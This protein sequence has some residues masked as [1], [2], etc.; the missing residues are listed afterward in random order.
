MK[1][2]KNLKQIKW[3]I[4]IGFL[5]VGLT[6]G[7]LA[8]QNFYPIL[9]AQ[10]S[11][12]PVGRNL[13]TQYQREIFN[14]AQK[15]NQIFPWT[16]FELLDLSQSP[17]GA[18]GFWVNPIGQI[19]EERF[20]GL[21]ARVN[22]KLNYFPDNQWG[23]LADALDAFGKDLLRILGEELENIPDPKVKGAVLVLIYSK[24]ELWEPNYFNHAEAIAIYIPRNS[25]KKFNSFLLTYN[26]LFSQAEYYY[27][28]GAYQIRFLLNEFLKG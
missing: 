9:I 4:F 27:F 15:A 1:W 19:S 20:L 18:V 23:R 5:A 12:S 24:K 3:L 6:Q 17:M 21:C 10:N 16:R 28:Q 13:I 22:I 2:S 11:Y 26:L 7:L 25:L 14:L 8:Q